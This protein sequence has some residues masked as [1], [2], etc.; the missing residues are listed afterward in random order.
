[1]RRL[2]GW[3]WSA[4]GTFSLGEWLSPLGRSVSIKSPYHVHKSELQLH[5]EEIHSQ[6]FKCTEKGANHLFYASSDVMQ[7]FMTRIKLFCYLWPKYWLTIYSP[8]SWMVIDI[9]VTYLT[10]LFL[11]SS[12]NIRHTTKLLPWYI[13]FWYLSLCWYFIVIAS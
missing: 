2:K 1:M 8:T 9:S 3:G 4:P 10:C 13:F 5:W 12:K 7:M 11:I 6:A